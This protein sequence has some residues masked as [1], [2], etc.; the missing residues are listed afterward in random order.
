M[1]NKYF[2][3]IDVAKK[4]NVATVRDLKSKQKTFS[5]GN[6][7]AGFGQLLSEISIPDTVI[8]L[9]STGPYHLPLTFHLIDSGCTVK[10]L[11]PLLTKKMA[12]ANI[13]KAKTDKIDSGHLA[14][15]AQLE[16][17]PS[18]AESREVHQLKMLCRHRAFLKREVERLKKHD[19]TIV[20]RQVIFKEKA[21][22]ERIKALTR[23][24]SLLL[25]ELNDQISATEDLILSASKDITDIALI[26]SVPGISRLLACMIYAELGDINRFKTTKALVAFSG[27]D[28]QIAQ[29]GDSLHATGKM[30]KRG[31]PYLRH[32][33]FLASKTAIRCDSDLKAYYQKK[34]AEGKHFYISMAAVSR[35]LLLRINSV[36][37]EQRPYRK[38]TD[39]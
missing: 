32:Y 23:R 4:E 9:E 33:L 21:H 35:K 10:L 13:R 38:S 27:I 36:L 15:L 24:D 26:D 1:K 19:S 20:F 16:D 11:N 5:F 6:N 31:S 2:V 29:S 17:R 8:S 37:K 39:T 7:R 22:K 34:K 12:K 18:F 30:S 3:G 25:L 14:W 28:P